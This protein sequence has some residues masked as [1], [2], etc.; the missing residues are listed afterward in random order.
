ML[1]AAQAYLARTGRNLAEDILASELEDGVRIV[2]SDT[3][4]DRVRALR[5]PLAVRSAYLSQ[6]RSGRSN[7]AAHA[8]HELSSRRSTSMSCAGSTRSSASRCPIL[9]A[10]HQ[11]P[12]RKGHDDLSL[13]I[14]LF[15]PRRAPG[16]L[17]YL[18]S[19]ES[20]MDSYSNEVSPEEAARQLRETRRP[21]HVSTRYPPGSQGPAMPPHLM[22]EPTVTAARYESVRWRAPGRVNLIGEHTDYNEG[23]AMPLAIDRT[24]AASARPLDEPILLLRSVQ[25][26]ARASLAL[27]DPAQ[28]ARMDGPGTSAVSSGPCSVTASSCPAWRS[29][30]TATSR[31]GRGSRHRP[32]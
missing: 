29:R 9:S 15:S 14:E 30:S 3:G 11:A 27:T 20:A 1:R 12:A 25:H 22:G 10:V 8:R 32:R 4:L 16:K 6:R 7:H 26:H 23:F 17:K 5:T 28:G 18:A 13:H 24:C 31:S 19:T 21:G 2:A